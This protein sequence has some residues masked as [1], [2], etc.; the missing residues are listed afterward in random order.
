MGANPE[1]IVDVIARRT[2]ECGPDCVYVFDLQGRLQYMN[3][4]ARKIMEVADFSSV[5]GMPWM[6]LW[7]PATHRDIRTSIEATSRREPFRFEAH[8]PTPRGTMKSWDVIVTPLLDDD[9]AL[10]GL[11]ATSRDATAAFLGRRE[12]EARN[13]DLARSTAMVHVASRIAQ[14]GGWEFDCA[15][16]QVRFSSQLVDMAGGGE[17]QQLSQALELWVEEDR[18]PFAQLL[19]EAAAKGIQLTFE[20]RIRAPDGSIRWMRVMGEPELDRGWCVAL[21]GA[22]QD[23]TEWRESLDRVQASERAAL[24]AADAMS[25]FLAT[26]SHEIRTPLNAV[27]G[28]AQAMERGD[29]PEVQRERLKVIETSGEALLALLNDLLDLSKIEAGKVELEEG[30][31]DPQALADAA[32]HFAAL[33]QNKDVSFSFQ[34]APSAQGLWSGDPNR[35]RQVLINLIGN[36]V[37]FTERGSVTVSVS[38]DDERLV[39]RVQDTGIGI[40]PE[41]LAQIFDR[42]VQADGSMTRRYGGSGLGLAISNDLVKLMGGDIEVESEEG[43]GTTFTVKLPAKRVEPPALTETLATSAE[44]DASLEGDLRV[45]AAEDNPTNQVVLKTLLA[46][47]GIDL[48][49]VSNGEEAVEA[50]T[51]GAWDLVLMDIQMPIMDGVSATRM[52]RER[53]SASGRRKTPIIALTA[54]AMAHHRA[55][56]LAA[57]LD[58][59]VAKPISLALL[60][61]AM[62]RQ[63]AT[64]AD[65]E[66]QAVA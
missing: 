61:Q 13:T 15:T 51:N 37:K 52:I 6:S 47:L 35:V 2:A 44:V 43:A 18:Q 36:A 56:Y 54:N 40:K 60:L 24:K 41:R 31:V 38:H 10:L 21:R 55:E 27:L 12:A 16:R 7:P 63:L 3:A 1:G 19:D 4:A 17:L 20:G 8:V 65:G 62:E 50:W 32:A 14:L 57:G 42:F 5:E 25:G 66:T 64:E 33:L 39:F 59:V 9:Q 46:E 22:S 29:L 58:D 45:L 34:L 53:E 48:V 23:I 26:M 28:M 11:M 49:M 30:V